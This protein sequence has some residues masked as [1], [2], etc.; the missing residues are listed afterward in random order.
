MEIPENFRAVGRKAFK[1]HNGS[2]FE[3]VVGM[4]GADADADQQSPSIGRY[5]NPFGQRRS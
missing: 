2:A 5:V 1:L 3:Q 4:A